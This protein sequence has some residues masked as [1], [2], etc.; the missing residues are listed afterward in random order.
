MD[1]RELCYQ[2]LERKK[3]IIDKREIQINMISTSK[4]EGKKWQER[5]E[6][7]KVRKQYKRGKKKR[8]RKN[9]QW[10]D[11]NHNKKK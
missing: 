8:K 2:V 11:K 5:E 7:E 3:E 1:K 10:V 9:E 6:N 4:N